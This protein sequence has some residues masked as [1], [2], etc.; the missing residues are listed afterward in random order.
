M[1]QMLDSVLFHGNMRAWAGLQAHIKRNWDQDSFT[2]WY[3]DRFSNNRSGDRVFIVA[4][5]SCDQV[6]RIDWPR[7]DP[8]SSRR[9]ETCRR[10]FRTYMGW[11]TQGQKEGQILV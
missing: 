7:N 4:C 11:G 6:C 10:T 1:I 9:L 5:N 8:Q 2:F 3:M